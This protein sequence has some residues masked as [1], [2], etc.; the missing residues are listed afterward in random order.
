MRPIAS[1]LLCLAGCAPSALDVPADGGADAVDPLPH[2]PG[3]A[4]VGIGPIDLQPGVEKTVCVNQRLPIDDPLV[5]NRIV[6]DLAPG[7]HHLIVYATDE[8]QEHSNP[9]DCSPFSHILAG[10][11]PL[12]IV[13]KPHDELAFPAGVG[14]LLDAHQMIKLEAHYINASPQALAGSAKVRF[15]GLRN[16][17]GTDFIPAAMAFWGTSSFKIPARSKG[18]TGVRFERGYTASSFF[19]LTTH[20][21][22]LAT[23]MRVWYSPRARDTSQVPIADTT[24]WAEPPLYRV[25]PPI[26]FDG[27]SGLS[28]RCEWNN[29]TDMQVGF[30]ESAN[31][32]MCFVWLY[33]FPSHGFEMCVD[34]TCVIK[35]G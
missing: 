7:S 29:T 18:D 17:T 8:T 21:H 4:S 22:H 30:G 19:A 26:Q 33:Y 11:R 24:N 2:G 3:S 23:R 25:D 14:L 9:V 13:Q 28:Y 35:N 5:I 12:T 1:L 10:D 32:E 27:V 16:A 20:Q 34:G 6:A 31:D 15:E